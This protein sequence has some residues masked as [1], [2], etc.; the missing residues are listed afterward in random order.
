[1]NGAQAIELVAGLMRVTMFVAGPILLGSLVAGLIVGIL[2]AA[3][4]INEA[5]VS[6]IA[7]VVSV[8]AVLVSVGP[9]IVTCAVNYARTTI[10]SIEHVVR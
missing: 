2:Q 3:T 10:S 1:V 9:A 5:S 7:K 8:S 6:F 4:Q